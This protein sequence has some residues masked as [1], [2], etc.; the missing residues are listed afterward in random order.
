MKRHNKRYF[1]VVGLTA[2]MLIVAN[3]ILPSSMASASTFPGINGR[4]LY[5]NTNSYDNYQMVTVKPNGTGSGAIGAND[6]ARRYASFSP[7]GTKIVYTSGGSW[8]Y[9]WIANADGTNAVQL[10]NGS[11]N[12][13]YPSFSPDGTKILYSYAVSSIYQLWTMNLDGSGA[14]ALYSP[15][16]HVYKASYSPNGEKIVFSAVFGGGDYEIGLM[17]ADGTGATN[18]TNNSQHDDDPSFSPDGTK[19]VYNSLALTD[20]A[21]YQIHTMNLDGS[22]TAQLTSASVYHGSP[23]YSP[24]GTKIA[25]RRG[26]SPTEL[27]YM[28][29]D[30]SG[31]TRVTTDGWVDAKIDW[32][33][34]TTAPTKTTSNPSI[35]LS[36]GSGSLNIADLYTDHYGQG[37][38]TESLTIVSGPS[39]GTTRV[40]TSTGAIEYTQT[41]VSSRSF[42]STFSSIFF[43]KV[44][45][46]ATDSFTYRICSNASN[47]LCST[48]S[49][50]VLGLSTS[51]TLSETGNSTKL[52]SNVAQITLIALASIFLLA[53]VRKRQH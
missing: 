16:E 50:S 48:G 1:S 23:V 46:A 8:Q 14:T 7:D 31:E 5:T 20:G 10:T 24:D 4:L 37:V 29:A 9:T 49:V 17:N 13:I 34:L 22:S 32:Q 33:P 30:G 42:W 3:V 15:S 51:S 25:Y 39:S 19:I 45:A 27:Y 47:E 26:G 43:P 36:N 28:N 44:S 2:V 53:Y 40:N 6:L 11:T 41:T 38:N 52:P 12:S 35:T 21:V 18:L